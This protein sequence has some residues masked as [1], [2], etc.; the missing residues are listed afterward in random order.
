MSLSTLIPGSAPWGIYSASSWNGATNTLPELQGTGRDAITTGAVATGSAMG[1]GASAYVDYI[2]GNNATSVQWPVGSLPTLFTLCTVTRYTGNRK[3][4]R[5]IQGITTSIALGHWGVKRG[6][7]FFSNSYK[8]QL[9]VSVGTLTNWLVVCGKNDDVSVSGSVL[10]DGVA[11]GIA[12][13]SGTISSNSAL[14]INYGTALAESSDFAFSSLLI[15]NKTLSDSQ[16]VS[17]STQL[18]Q[19]LNPSTGSFGAS[20][21][22]SSSCPAGLSDTFSK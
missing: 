7:V 15:W 12:T 4:G 8:T 14:G 22:T 2:S 3:Y 19:M 13:G 9:T 5:I 17:V 10:L 1:N 16:M 6:I 21:C 20:M 11:S 18:L